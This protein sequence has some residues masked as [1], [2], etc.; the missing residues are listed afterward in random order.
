MKSPRLQG[1]AVDRSF[2]TKW[3]DLRVPIAETA[4]QN[5][6][7]RPCQNTRNAPR[8]PAETGLRALLTD[9]RG[10]TAVMFALLMIPL[11]GIVGVA[12]DAS[13][14]YLVK[15]RLS[16][17]L[18]AAAL[19]AG[20]VALDGDAEAV[21][22]R[23]FEANFGPGGETVDIGFQLDPSRQFVTLTA[24]FQER[25]TF[26]RLLGQNVMNVNARVRVQRRTTGLEL[27]LVMDNTGS[28]AGA[29]FQAMETAA[30]DLVDLIYGDEE[31]IE[32]LWIS[33]VPYVASVNAGPNRT[34]WLTP[35]DRAITNPASFTNQGWRGCVEARAHPLDSDDTPPSAG[36]FTSYFYASTPG[37]PQDNEWPPLTWNRGPNLACG[38]PITSLTPRRAD[39]DAAID[40]MSA[41]A[42]GGTA[43]NLGLAWG[44]RTISPRWRG[45]WGGRTPAT[46]PLDYRTP[47]MEKVVVIL[48]DGNNQFADEDRASG[49]PPSD[50]TAYRRLE[51]L[52]VT[53][54]SQGRQILD[55]RM[56]G[57]CT[58]MKAEGI[59]I[60]SIIF[61]SG[62]DAAAQRL[63]RECATTP[64]M[65]FLAP[66]AATLQTTF[67]AIGGQLANLRIVE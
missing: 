57:T 21:A 48:T 34:A 59:R 14:G 54:L 42:R 61:G 39:V 20:R 50:Y 19:A 44:W 55:Q 31:E 25:T 5:A 27:A 37:R 66:N 32:N 64:A 4:R 67:R 36:P 33:V 16:K 41:I 40:A 11:L 1:V 7:F 3:Q 46:H 18:D 6:V 43:G 49:T 38:S 52:G 28:M 51:P 22:Q 29:P 30:Y 12:V 63:F 58:A 23:Y 62:P 8:R 24:Q 60:Y 65:Y 2:T 35:T 17:S 9:R 53:T 15:T 45:L 26:M 10:V 47:F 56:A 13:R